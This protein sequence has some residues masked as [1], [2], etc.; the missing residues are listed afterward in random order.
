MLSVLLCKLDGFF[1]DT[2][3]DKRCR[4][5]TRGFALLIHPCFTPGNKGFRAIRVSGR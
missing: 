1:D 2:A 4:R 5:S 3:E